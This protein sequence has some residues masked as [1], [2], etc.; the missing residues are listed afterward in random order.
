[1]IQAVWKDTVIAESDRIA[2]V[3][4]NAYFPRTAVNADYVRESADTQGTYCHWKGM[5]SYYDIVVDGARNKGA[6]W[7]YPSPHDE[8]SPIRDHIAFWNGVEIIGA[9]E[10][11]GL[12]ERRPSVIVDRTGWK[13]LCWHLKFTDEATLSPDQVAEKIGIP[14]HDVGAAWAAYDVQRYASHYKWRL[15]DGAA[16]GAAPWIERFD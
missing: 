15:I 11:P 5:A 1:M 6:A 14:A 9:P 8:A 10:G 3:E 7:W 2:P 16:Q 13:A 4:G 12:V